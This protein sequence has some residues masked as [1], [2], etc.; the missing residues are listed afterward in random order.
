MDQTPEDIKREKK[1]SNKQ[2]DWKMCITLEQ[3][4]SLQI[5]QVRFL[6]IVDNK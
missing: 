3:T 5:P 1:Q 4:T 6:K 2:C